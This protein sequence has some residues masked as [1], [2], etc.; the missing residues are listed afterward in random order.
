MSRSY[1]GDS[2]DAEQWQIAAWVS[3][4]RRS[5]AGKRGQAFLREML[6]AMHV[7]GE[8]KLVRSELELDG[9]VCAIGCVGKVRGI[10]MSKLDPLDHRSVAETFKIGHAMAAEIASMNDDH[11]HRFETPSERFERMRMW[12]ESQIIDETKPKDTLL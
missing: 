7:L 11:G 12:I 9:A 8:R 5:F 4:V 3:A 1:D 10:D 6:E 2:D